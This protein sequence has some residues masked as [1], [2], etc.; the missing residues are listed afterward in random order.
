MEMQ[1][2]FILECILLFDENNILIYN[3][4]MDWDLTIYN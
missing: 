2:C 3:S 1:F 4:I